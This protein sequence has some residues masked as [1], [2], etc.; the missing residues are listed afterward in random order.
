MDLKNDSC[1]EGA[2]GLG[3]VPEGRG[4]DGACG[5]ATVLL[6]ATLAPEALEPDVGVVTLTA[7]SD[8]LALLG[9]VVV[10]TRGVWSADEAWA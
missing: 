3:W 1:V 6:L 7:W 8:L 4:G 9:T 10:E 2:A 5:L